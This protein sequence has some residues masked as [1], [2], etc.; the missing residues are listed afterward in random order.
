LIS[1]DGLNTTDTC[2]PRSVARACASYD[3]GHGAGS[4]AFPI[5]TEAHCLTST[6]LRRRPSRPTR[7]SVRRPSTRRKKLFTPVNSC[8][9]CTAGLIGGRSG[10]TGSRSD[11]RI[12]TPDEIGRFS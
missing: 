11:P 4:T 9:Y 6:I 12:S 1:C 5:A 7:N 8:E 3:T 2:P 10:A